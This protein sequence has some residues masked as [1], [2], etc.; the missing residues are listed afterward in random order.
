MVWL[1]LFCAG[2]YCVCACVSA[3]AL[4]KCSRAL[5]SALQLAVMLVLLLC[6]CKRPNDTN[7]RGLCVVCV[8]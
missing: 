8:F 5:Q 6:G 4:C 1:H 7:G 3:E 2:A